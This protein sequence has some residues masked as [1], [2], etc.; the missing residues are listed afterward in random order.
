MQAL[1]FSSISKKII[2]LLLFQIILRILFSIMNNN[3]KTSCLHDNY[4]FIHKQLISRYFRVHYLEDPPMLTALF[5]CCFYFSLWS[6]VVVNWSVNN[7][8][9]IF[10]YCC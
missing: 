6:A 1:A 3:N 7:S 10:L 4:Y 9:S 2:L 8:Q 5:T